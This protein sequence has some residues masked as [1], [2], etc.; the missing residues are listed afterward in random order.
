MTTKPTTAKQMTVTKM[1]IDEFGCKI[2][3]KMLRQ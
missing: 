1:A 2:H 3:R